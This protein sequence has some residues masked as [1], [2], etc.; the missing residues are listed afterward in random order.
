M[1]LWPKKHHKISLLKNII[2]SSLSRATP[3]PLA[4]PPPAFAVGPRRG[5]DRGGGTLSKFI[6]MDRQKNEVNCLM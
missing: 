5:V 2:S 6:L 4:V 3:F 1:P